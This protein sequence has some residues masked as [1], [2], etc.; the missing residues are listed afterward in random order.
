MS[1]VFYLYL[2]RCPR[3]VLQRAL[4]SGVDP[5]STTQVDAVDT[6]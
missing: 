4:V 5:A 6:S 2:V 1:N 3:G